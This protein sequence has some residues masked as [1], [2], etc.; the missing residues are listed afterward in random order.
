M[1][2]LT[3]LLLIYLMKCGFYLCPKQLKKFNMGLLCHIIPYGS[4][5]VSDLE[6]LRAVT[7]ALVTSCMDYW[8]AIYLGLSLKTKRKLQLVQ[9][10]QLWANHHNICVLLLLNANQG[11]DYYSEVS[12]FRSTMHHCGEGDLYKFGKEMHIMQ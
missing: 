6:G 9:N 2:S 5:D 8:N 11:T 12:G 3:N 7:H 1:N 4:C 10:G